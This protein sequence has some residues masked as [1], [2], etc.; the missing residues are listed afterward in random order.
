MPEVQ[1]QGTAVI[2]HG[3]QVLAMSFRAAD[4]PAHKTPLERSR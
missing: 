3:D 1:N 2:E 4:T